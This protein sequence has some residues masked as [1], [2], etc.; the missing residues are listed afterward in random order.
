MIA[1]GLVSAISMALVLIYQGANYHW[2]AFCLCLQNAAS[3]FSNVIIDAILVVQARR[4]P[5]NGSADLQ[6][7]SWSC[8]AFGG[9][10]G[11]VAAAII[12]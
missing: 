11:A 6:S 2:I 12:T 9:M 7:F 5:K 10:V 4:Y 3:A 8:Y 1:C